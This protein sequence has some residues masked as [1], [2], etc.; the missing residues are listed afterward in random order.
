MIVRATEPMLPH[1]AIDW[2]RQEAEC[3]D[4]RTVKRALY[5]VAAEWLEGQRLDK[6]WG[7][8]IHQRIKEANFDGAEKQAR[9]THQEAWDGWYATAQRVIALCRELDAA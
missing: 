9:S 3:E 1:A 2:V 5:W 4:V 8:I 7:S 6:L